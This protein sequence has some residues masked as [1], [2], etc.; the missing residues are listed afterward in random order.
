MPKTKE[1]KRKEA[2]ERNRTL[3]PEKVAYY[4]EWQLGGKH[5]ENAVKIKDR[6]YAVSCASKERIYFEKWCKSVN[7]DTHGNVV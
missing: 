6:N 7:L 5:F 2:I 1:Q 4:L 3:F